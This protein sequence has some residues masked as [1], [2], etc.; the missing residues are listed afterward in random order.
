MKK[1]ILPILA[2]I[3]LVIGLSYAEIKIQGEPD[4]IKELIAQEDK[5]FEKNV[6]LNDYLSGYVNIG[7]TTP[8][9]VTVGTASTVVLAANPARQYAIIVNDSDEAIYLSLGNDAQLNKGIRLNASGGSY[10]ILEENMFTGRV[11]A[12]S[13]SGS[14]VLTYIEN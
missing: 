13:T 4:E 11:T 7:S 12:I 2:A 5:T 1:L 9:S 6:R 8:Q 3:L 10:E 14:K